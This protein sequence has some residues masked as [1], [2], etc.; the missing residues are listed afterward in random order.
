M[1]GVTIRIKI[2]IIAT[3][4]RAEVYL[5]FGFLGYTQTRLPCSLIVDTESLY[6]DESL[7]GS[8]YFWVFTESILLVTESTLSLQILPCGGFAFGGFVP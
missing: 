5:P 6:E 4:V 8:F 3:T 1:K 7:K 2:R